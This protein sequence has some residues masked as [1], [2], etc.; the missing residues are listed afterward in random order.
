MS[1]CPNFKKLAYI[2]TK[3]TII[4]LVLVLFILL[5]LAPRNILAIENE[6]IIAS[7]TGKTALD[8][9]IL[10]IKSIKDFEQKDQT[11][12]TTK[13]GIYYLK[14]EP[15]TKYLIKYDNK[16]NVLADY[17]G[18]Y[19][20]SQI[21]GDRVPLNYIVLS[22]NG[23]IALASK[24]IPHFVSQSAHVTHFLL[25]DQEFAGLFDKGCFEKVLLPPKCLNLI[26][27]Y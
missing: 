17:V 21:I 3:T 26:Y 13:G 27:N 11:T 12:G 22:E 18:A 1:T 24:F 14:A 19:I 7:P 4:P 2:S 16:T 5:I 6:P 25:T 9:S 15:D 10:Q 20:L 8:E 23:D